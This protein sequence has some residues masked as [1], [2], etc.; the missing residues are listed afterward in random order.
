LFLCYFFW[1]IDFSFRSLFFYSFSCFFCWI[2][3]WFNR[4]IYRIPIPTRLFSYYFYKIVWRS[5]CWDFCLFFFTLNCFSLIFSYFLLLML[6]LSIFR[7]RKIFLV[8]I[9]LLAFFA[10]LFIVFFICLSSN[11]S[12]E[13]RFVIS[14]FMLFSLDFRI[15]DWLSSLPC[16]ARLSFFCS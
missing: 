14:F 2:L 8:L 6:I 4:C 3:D 5:R 11:S 13:I 15:L 12:L 10:F 1:R 7:Y 9:T 16:L